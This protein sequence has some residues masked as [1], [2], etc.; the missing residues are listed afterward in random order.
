MRTKIQ[1]GKNWALSN[2]TFETEK[3]LSNSLKKVSASSSR[4][5]MVKKK[6][7]ENQDFIFFA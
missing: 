5:P 7:T 1:H 6:V 3:K 2:L 4:I